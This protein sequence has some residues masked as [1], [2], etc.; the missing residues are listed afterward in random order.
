MIPVVASDFTLGAVNEMLESIEESPVSALDT[1]GT[2]IEA[3]AETTLDRNRRSILEEGRQ[4]NTD[5]NVTLSPDVNKHIILDA[6]VLR[7]DTTRSS[8]FLNLSVKDGRLYNR[9]EQT[10]E[11]D[12]DV[13]VDIVRL[14]SFDNCSEKMRERITRDSKLEFQRRVV[15]SAQQDAFLRQEA[16][17]SR[18][19]LD[20]S[21]QEVADVNMLDGAMSVGIL[22][23]RR[24]SRPSTR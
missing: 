17:Q 22:G 16:G 13:Q 14:L 5:I 15:G 12:G 23:Q 21:E 18:A 3:Q 6:D 19:L 20:R 1:G 10:D 11:F 9:D 24:F 7:I 2:S 8:T 4:E